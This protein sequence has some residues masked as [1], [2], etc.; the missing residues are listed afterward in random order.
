[1]NRRLAE[2]PPGQLDTTIL[3]ISAIMNAWA[4]TKCHEGASNVEMWLNRAME[5]ERLGNPNVVTNTKMYTMAVD[6]WA[7]S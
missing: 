3:P 2:T 5:E 6:A 1:M 7:K 4:K